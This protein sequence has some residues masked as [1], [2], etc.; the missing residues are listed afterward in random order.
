M[1]KARLPQIDPE[2]NRL[3]A[4]AAELAQ[5][6]TLRCS[7]PEDFTSLLAAARSVMADAMWLVEQQKL[8]G[9]NICSGEQ[10]SFRYR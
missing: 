8:P 7:K 4:F 3:A 1:P 2:D 9:V 10:P 6:A 5:L